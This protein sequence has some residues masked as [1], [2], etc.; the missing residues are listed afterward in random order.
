MVGWIGNEKEKE[1]HDT[2]VVDYEFDDINKQQCFVRYLC[3][4]L[5]L[6]VAIRSSPGIV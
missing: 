4:V 6:I 1:N 2:A 3:C 5:S